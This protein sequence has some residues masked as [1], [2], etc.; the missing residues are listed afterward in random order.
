MRRKVFISKF[1]NVMVPGNILIKFVWYARFF[2]V[3]LVRKK[4]LGN[5][6]LNIK[7]MSSNS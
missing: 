1:G 2:K 6:D 7:Q 5:T 3:V 4:S